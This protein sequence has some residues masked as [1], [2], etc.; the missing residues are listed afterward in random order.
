[1]SMVFTILFMCIDIVD[2]WFG[3]ADGQITSAFD[4]VIYPSHINGDIISCFYF[5]LS[6]CRYFDKSFTE[7]FLE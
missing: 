2:I 6:F 7:M 3:I 1:M 5:F 4:R